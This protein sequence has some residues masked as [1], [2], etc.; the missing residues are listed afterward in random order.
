MGFPKIEASFPS[1]DFQ[2]SFDPSVDVMSSVPQVQGSRF[3]SVEPLFDPLGRV[4]PLQR[5]R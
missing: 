4:L 5:E 3:V 1:F 2:Q